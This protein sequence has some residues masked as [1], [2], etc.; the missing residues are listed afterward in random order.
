METGDAENVMA[1]PARPEAPPVAALS[2]S[3]RVAAIAHAR[4]ERKRRHSDPGVLAAATAATAS[5]TAEDVQASKVRTLREHRSKWTERDLSLPGSPAKAAGPTANVGDLT[6]VAGNRIV[7]MESFLSDVLPHICCPECSTLGAMVALAADEVSHGLAGT[8]V[9]KCMRCDN[10]HIKWK[11]T[12]DIPKVRNDKG[13]LPPGPAQKDLNLRAVLGS[14]QCGIGMRQLERLLGVLEIPSMNW[15][16]YKQV[17]G[18]LLS[19]LEHVGALSQS[20]WLLLKNAALLWQRVLNP[21]R[22]GENPSP[23][24]SIH[25]G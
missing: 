8:M 11:Q 21:G 2:C 6:Q 22:T 15:D 12:A 25:N 17:L 9:M 1:T 4:A 23:S 7:S 14:L 16:T 19:R 5:A 10:G 13:H 20:K 18:S 3:G 24:P